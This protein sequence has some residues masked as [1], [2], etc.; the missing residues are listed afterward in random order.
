[1]SYACWLKRAGNAQNPKQVWRNLAFERHRGILAETWSK[2]ALLWFS[3]DFLDVNPWVAQT[4][5]G[6]FHCAVA[7]SILH[8]DTCGQGAGHSF[9]PDT[10]RYKPILNRFWI[11]EPKKTW[12]CVYGFK[13][14]AQVLNKFVENNF[15][16]LERLL[17]MHEE[18]SL[19]AVPFL[20][21]FLVFGKLRNTY[22]C[23]EEYKYIGYYRTYGQQPICPSL[24]C[25]PQCRLA[26]STTA[27]SKRQ[28]KNVIRAW[29]KR[30]IVSLL[31]ISS[32]SVLE[33]VVLFFKRKVLVPPPDSIY[34][35][36]MHDG[37]QTAQKTQPTKAGSKRG[38]DGRGNRACLL[39]ASKNVGRILLSSHYRGGKLNYHSVRIIYSESF[40]H[41]QRF[42]GAA[43]P[44]PLWC[45]ALH[46]AAGGPDPG[47][48]R[49]KPSNK[50]V[51]SRET[52]ACSF[53]EF[54]SYPLI[55]CH[56]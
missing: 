53:H 44:G 32:W 7:L 40:G 8:R 37:A 34:Q 27:L 50:S 22:T 24:L 28:T 6:D 55:C 45:R 47:A 46:P 14:I 5:Q 23:T 31:T 18:G 48:A 42:T 36:I 49:A 10:F 51:P 16:K 43:V 52:V 25:L 21:S 2:P 56:S 29:H 17:E 41:L 12:A 33:L 30:S 39:R 11:L 19:Y 20:L 26:R 54:L 15:E 1:M 13:T 35:W 3:I 4:H 9:L 38:G